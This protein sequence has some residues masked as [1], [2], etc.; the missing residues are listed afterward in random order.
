MSFFVEWVWIR[1][2]VNTSFPGSLFQTWVGVGF[3]FLIQ[4]YMI[5]C[6]WKCGLSSSFVV[7][8]YHVFGKGVFLFLSCIWTDELGCIEFFFLVGGS[9]LGVVSAV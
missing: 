2:C 9:R 8:F 3:G 1:I 7:V 4:Q 6:D 5:M